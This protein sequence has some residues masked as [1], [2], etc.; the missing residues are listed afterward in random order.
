[1]GLRTKTISGK[2]YYYLELSYFIVDSAKKFS[3]YVGTGKPALHEIAKLEDAFRD[4]IIQKLGKQTYSA[5]SFSKDEVIKTLL[6]RDAFNEKYKTLSP[7]QRKKFE[8]NRTILFTLTTLTTEDVDVDLQD[9]MAAYKKEAKLDARE[10]ISKNMLEG[11]SRIKESWKL[12]KKSVLSLHKTIMASFETK[13]PGTFRQRQVYIHRQ[14]ENTL[15]GIEIAYRPP[16]FLEIPNQM[17]EMTEWYGSSTLNP[18]E[19]AARIHY[20]FYS[21]HPFLDGNKR[22]ARLLFNKALLENNFPLLNISEK[23]ED[24]FRA[25]IQAVETKKIRPFA[26]FSL[27]EYYRQ[28]RQ[29]LTAK[30]IQNLTKTNPQNKRKK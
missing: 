19:K 23:K 25:L 1:M 24:Y 10:T 12:D 16:A 18:V 21:I 17:R 8:V 13:N 26:E 6:F 29:F 15:F 20:E 28:V 14:D 7:V 2:T 11:V 30:N 3:K 27:G 5:E 22:M 9:V 4:E